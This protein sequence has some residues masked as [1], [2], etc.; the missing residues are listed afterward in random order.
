MSDQPSNQSVEAEEL[1][2]YLQPLRTLSE[3]FR[4]DC[5]RLSA[6]A[7][8]TKS[9]LTKQAQRLQELTVEDS[10]PLSEFRNTLLS[11]I[12]AQSLMLDEQSQTMAP[13]IADLS[14]TAL[15]VT[16][17]LHG[18]DEDLDEAL[19]EFE[20]AEAD[21]EDP[22]GEEDSE[23]Q[24][25]DSMLLPEDGLLFAGLLYEFHQVA[26]SRMG[27]A[28]DEQERAGLDLKLREI[29]RAIAR[30]E[31]ITSSAE[32]PEAPSEQQPPPPAEPST[33]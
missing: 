26:A 13:M 1:P 28:T 12:D 16:T 14:S 27:Q 22:E 11:L 24:F 18:Q 21:Y 20:E 19:A 8:E 23:G 5:G 7:S 29:A 32:Q 17:E 6:V 10:G 31:E 9:K 15:S 30:I 4:A 2:E 33:A 3:E 25:E